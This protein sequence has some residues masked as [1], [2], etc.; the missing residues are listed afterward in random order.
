LGVVE[1]TCVVGDHY[2]RHVPSPLSVPDH[3]SAT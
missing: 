2:E 1:R 3:H